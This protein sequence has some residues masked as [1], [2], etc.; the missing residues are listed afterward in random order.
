MFGLNLLKNAIATLAANVIGL[1]GTVKEIDTNLRQRAALDGPD[2]AESLTL[3]VSVPT[4]VQEESSPAGGSA[5]AS[6]SPTSRSNGRR[7]PVAIVTGR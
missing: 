4:F 7:K 5:V 2:S 6:T 3:P 1:A